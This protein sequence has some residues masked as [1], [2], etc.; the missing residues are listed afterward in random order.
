M[1]YLA[2]LAE[3]GATNLHPR[4]R[5][6]TEWLIEALNLQA[7]Y[8][9]LEIGCG[10]GET[11][12]RIAQRFPVSVDGLDVLPE[13][14]RVARIRLWLTGQQ[15][16]TRLYRSEVG[17][18]LPFPDHSYDR[19]Y[20]ESVLGFQEAALA[21]SLLTEIARVLK[22][23]GVYVAND[24]I[25][26]SHVTE[27]AVRVVNEACLRDFGSRVASERAWSVADW[28]RLMREAGFQVC[29]ADT[30][31]AHAERAQEEARGFSG[32][33]SLSK[34]LTLCCGVRARLNPRLLRQ[35][36]RYRALLEKQR[37]AE[38]CLEG[39]LFV[40]RTPLEETR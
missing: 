22:P 27:E 10:T 35:R 29:S 14:L 23:G 36:A 28:L 39:R 34:A 15:K 40:L 3:L 9:I 21:R 33:L 26:L 6:A 38:R 13:M 19:V 1:H 7:G 25:W 11:I 30:L 8:R 32:D 17:A 24:A 12:A 4:G 5:H 20:T 37:S 16:K 2:H 31:E 18:P